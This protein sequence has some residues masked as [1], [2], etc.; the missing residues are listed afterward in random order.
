MKKKFFSLAF[1]LIG[2]FVFANN[3]SSNEL[4][5]NTLKTYSIEESIYGKD[6]VGTCIIKIGYYDEDGNRV[7]GAVLVFTNVDTSEDCDAIGRM[8]EEVLASF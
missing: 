2:T 8:V 1:L 4:P 6:L 7:G 3:G 5:N